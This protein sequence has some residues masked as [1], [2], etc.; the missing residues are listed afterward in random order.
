MIE[1]LAQL[2]F[3]TLH[4]RVDAGRWHDFGFD[5]LA[6]ELGPRHVYSPLSP[7]ARLLGHYLQPRRGPGLPGADALG[8]PL[9]EPSADFPDPW[10]APSLLAHAAPAP[11]AD[12][13]LR[14]LA[15][16][17]PGYERGTPTPSWFSECPRRYDEALVDPPP[18][19][20]G[21]E[22]S[23]QRREVLEPMPTPAGIALADALHVLVVEAGCRRV[24]LS[25]SSRVSS[26]DVMSG[27]RLFAR[28]HGEA[29]A[30]VFL[31]H[32][33]RGEAEN[34]VKHLHLLHATGAY[35]PGRA[36]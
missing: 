15:V 16:V 1:S 30:T 2:T 7:V 22:P 26:A 17:N 8:R 14:A 24:G 18:G 13:A 31:Y 36:R 29:E 19:Y 27:V 25:K 11:E 35:Q 10:R 28:C 32:E 23:V 12:A 9:F 20:E 6:I 21:G 3:G 4:V 34:L 5:G 33:S